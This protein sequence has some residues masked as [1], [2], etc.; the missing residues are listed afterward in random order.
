MISII[1]LE[2][3]SAQLIDSI[4]YLQTRICIYYI[5]KKTILILLR[6]N[7]FLKKNALFRFGSIYPVGVYC[8]NSI[9]FGVTIE[10]RKQQFSYCSKSNISNSTI[11]FRKHSVR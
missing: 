11:R 2:N 1:N 5:Y 4:S 10:T 9:N 6:L 3:L 8:D 7:I